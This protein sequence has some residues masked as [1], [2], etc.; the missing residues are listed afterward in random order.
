MG[1]QEVWDTTTVFPAGAA[2]KLS[3]KHRVMSQYELEGPL[4]KITRIKKAINF[5]LALH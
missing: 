1:I 4:T 3:A 2:Q 5:D